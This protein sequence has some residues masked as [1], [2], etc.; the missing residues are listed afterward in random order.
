M[1]CPMKEL[2]MIDRLIDLGS[3]K[4]AI[5]QE[6]IEH[7]RDIHQTRYLENIL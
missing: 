5:K 3:N 2:S 6:D 1:V 7:A 4:K